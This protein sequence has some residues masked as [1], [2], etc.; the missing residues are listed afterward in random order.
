MN[1]NNIIKE[2]YKKWENKEYVYEKINNEY[3]S[4]TYGE[5]IKRTTDLA[6]KLIDLGL[7]D[8]RIIIF[9]K[10]SIDYMVS[11][12]AVL[13]YVGI[14]VNINAQTTEYELQEI[15][16]TMEIDAVL[17]DNDKKEIIDLIKDEHKNRKFICMQETIDY[18]DD[19]MVNF[20]FE[21]KD[22]NECSKIVFSSGT[23][24][25][26][27]GIMLSLKNIFAGWESL[28]RRTPLSENDVVYLFLPLHHTYGNIYNFIYSL[29]SGMSIYLCSGIENISSELK[30]V[31]PTIFCA[32]PLIYKKIYFENKENLENAFGNRIKYLFCGGSKFDIEI[33]MQY[34]QKGLPMLE[35]YAL[36]ETA[37][38]LSIEYPGSEDYESAGTI[39]EDIDVKIINEDASG[40]GDIVVKGDNVF[41]GYANNEK[42]TSIVFTDDGYFITGDYGYIND[43][44][45]YI[46]GRRD[47]VLV[48]DNGEN[49][50]PKEIENK[51]KNLCDKII[52]AKSFLKDGKLACNIYLIK[53]SNINIEEIIGEYNK[54]VVKKDRIYKFFVF[55]DSKIDLK[56]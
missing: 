51:L 33:R 21:D 38:S 9:G 25:N 29:L 48:G 19:S 20:D 34:K 54:Q 42:L 17:Y 30:E 46:K 10:N 36:T 27:K 53:D 47:T 4:I 3:K 26:P 37:S 14:S 11:D 24:S 49:I 5:F 55:K 31:N 6:K 56:Q 2:A 8:K 50:Y 18:S 41:L 23:T 15:L 32:V 39:F 12:L 35:A 13:A 52:K 7:K 16:K 43:N 45:L 1:I 28:N 44:K 40:I 22:I